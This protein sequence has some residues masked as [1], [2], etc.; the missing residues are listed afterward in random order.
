MMAQAKNIPV[1]NL[2]LMRKKRRMKM[3]RRRVH[4]ILCT[5]S[6][7]EGEG[8]GTDMQMFTDPL[9]HGEL[10]GLVKLL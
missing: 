3:A 1:E 5:F 7:V 6:H 2:A 10:T 9:C 8:L 4:S